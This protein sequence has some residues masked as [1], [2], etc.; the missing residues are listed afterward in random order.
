MYLV[1]F[2]RCLLLVSSVDGSVEDD[3]GEYEHDAKQQ[4]H[5]YQFE[6]GCFW[7]AG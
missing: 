1:R 2:V 3:D 7:Q 4:P 5:V 6:V